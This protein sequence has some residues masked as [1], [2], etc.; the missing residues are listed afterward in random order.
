MYASQLAR[1]DS[2]E[3]PSIEEERL[4]GKAVGILQPRNCALVMNY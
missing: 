4:E 1:L 3:I 2:D